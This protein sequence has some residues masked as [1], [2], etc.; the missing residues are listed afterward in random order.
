MSSD[1][2]I[3]VSSSSP[4]QPQSGRGLTIENPMVILSSP[5]RPTARPTAPKKKASG[6]RHA[7]A[8]TR[9]RQPASVTRTAASGSAGFNPSALFNRNIIRGPPSVILQNSRSTAS[10]AVPRASP[11]ARHPTT[12]PSRL[13]EDIRRIDE[14]R[15]AD[16]LAAET[17]EAERRAW[18]ERRNVIR[19][20]DP[21]SVARPPALTIPHRRQVD[22][23]WRATHDEELTAADLYQ[24]EARPPPQGTDRTHQRC[25]ICLQIKSHGVGYS[26]GH[27]HC[28]V[29]IRL[30][31]EEEFT[32]PIC[33]AV[34]HAP[35]IRN[36]DHLIRCTF[37]EGYRS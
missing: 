1:N 11:Y 10:N 12:N 7:P 5:E 16:R 31:L 4:Q 30:W 3:L 18:L 2:H 14:R 20:G 23:G 33:R 17:C 32:C 26:C 21:A 27:G 29:C 6:S 36:L 15:A 25:S 9:G 19:F 13:S 8:P 22:P 24:T 35:P 28:Y 37:R 34:M